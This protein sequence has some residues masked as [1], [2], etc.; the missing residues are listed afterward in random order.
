MGGRSKSSSSSSVDNSSEVVDQ[1]GVTGTAVSAGDNSKIEITATDHGAV[2]GS[3]DLVR[4]TYTES[5]SFGDRALSMVSSLAQAGQQ[6][7]AQSQQQIGQLAESFQSDGE[8]RTQ[9]TILVIAGLT[10]LVV[11]AL[12][13]AQRSNG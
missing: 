7:A 9:K 1:S 3:F 11:V 13:F 2:A 8:S 10:T 6:A 4:D 12:A 5:M